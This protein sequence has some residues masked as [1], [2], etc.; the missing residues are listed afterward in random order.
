MAFNGNFFYQKSDFFKVNG[1]VNH[2]K[3]NAGEDDLFLKDAANKKNTT[4]CISENS[5][6]EKENPSSFFSWFKE[7]RDLKNIAR[8]Y[9][10]KHRFLLSFFNFSKLLFTS[11]GFSSF[12]SEN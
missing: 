5:F 7:K 10:L 12:G 1:F 4:F 11:E 6:V 3:I 8:N 2:M 9:K